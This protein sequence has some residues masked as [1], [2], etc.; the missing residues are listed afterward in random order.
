MYHFYHKHTTL[1]GIYM[2][3]TIEHVCVCV[4]ALEC[5]LSSSSCMLQQI[6]EHIRVASVL[7]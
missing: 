4:R 5:P 1:K 3:G 7:L 2:G 6:K